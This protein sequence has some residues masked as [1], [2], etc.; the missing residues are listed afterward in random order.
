MNQRGKLLMQLDETIL[1][2]AR[3]S[4]DPDE[5]QDWVLYL[6]EGLDWQAQGDETREAYNT[7]LQRVRDEIQTRLE[8]EN[9][10]VKSISA[11]EEAP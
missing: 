3:L 4:S 6:L 5:W 2:I 1:D 9:W 8:H 7:A 10:W 11:A